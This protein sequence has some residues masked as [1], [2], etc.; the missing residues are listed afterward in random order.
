MKPGPP[1]E[2][3]ILHPIQTISISI[4]RNEF[5]PGELTS[6]TWAIQFFRELDK[7]GDKLLRVRITFAHKFD[8]TKHIS[9]ISETVFLTILVSTSN[10]QASDDTVGLLSELGQIAISHATALFHQLNPGVSIPP[11]IWNNKI[12][13]EVIRQFIDPNP[14]Q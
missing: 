8:A 10:L 2:Q 11:A 3:T 1:P 12:R 4:L 6:N 9:H 14:W 7:D 13:P 5:V